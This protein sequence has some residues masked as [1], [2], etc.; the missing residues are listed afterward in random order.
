M[1]S[2]KNNINAPT[3]PVEERCYTC[4]RT[5]RELGIKL[6]RCGACRSVNYCSVECQIEDWNEHSKVCQQV[7]DQLNNNTND[8]PIEGGDGEEG[9]VDEEKTD[10]DGDEDGQYGE[11]E[12][13]MQ[14]ENNEIDAD[15]SSDTSDGLSPFHNI[16]RNDIW[17]NEN[18]NDINEFQNN[19]NNN[20][21]NNT[22]DE[23]V[24]SD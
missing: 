10:E 7:T 24:I 16:N 6:K 1:N 2:S 20:N 13:Q 15:Y 5:E 11:P 4:K 21:N 9:D 14:P 8:D 22:M 17:A 19:N 12:K 23:I 18:D 3:K